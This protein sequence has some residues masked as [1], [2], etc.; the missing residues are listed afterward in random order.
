MNHLTSL[1]FPRFCTTVLI[2][3]KK[4]IPK[5]PRTPEWHENLSGDASKLDQ[6]KGKQKKLQPQVKQLGER[7]KNKDSVTS[8]RAI[9]IQEKLKEE[10]R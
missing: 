4:T 10:V 7:L 3:T 8:F 9:L 2:R 6:L 1:Y 5:K